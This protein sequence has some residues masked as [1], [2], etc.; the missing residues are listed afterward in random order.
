LHWVQVMVAVGDCLQERQLGMAVLQVM[1]VLLR[2][3]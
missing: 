3:K 1:Q 2:L